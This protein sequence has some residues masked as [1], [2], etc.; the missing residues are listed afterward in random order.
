MELEN[1]W[2]R[3]RNLCSAFL[4][5]PRDFDENH[6]SRVHLILVVLAICMFPTEY[7]CY[8]CWYNTLAFINLALMNQHKSEHDMVPSQW[9]FISDGNLDFNPDMLRPEGQ[10]SDKQNQGVEERMDSSS[11]TTWGKALQTVI[12]NSD[13]EG[14]VWFPAS[15]G[16]A[17]Y[18]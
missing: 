3:H 11:L 18:Y 14:C 5:L 7:W 12:Q 17:I 9:E 10:T 13:C 4:H 6:L 1:P 8:D 15:R 2:V 16:G